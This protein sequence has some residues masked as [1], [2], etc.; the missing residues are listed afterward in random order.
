MAIWDFFKT[1]KKPKASSLSEDSSEDE[2]LK[3]I[4][5]KQKEMRKEK[6]ALWEQQLDNLRMRQEQLKM[7]KEIADIESQLSEFD[8][9]DDDGEDSNSSD[10]MSPEALLTGIVT[11]SLAA[12]KQTITTEAP[13]QTSL[14]TFSDEQIRQLKEQLPSIYKMQLHILSDDQVKAMIK[15]KF[16]QVDNDTLNRAVGILR[17]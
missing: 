15:M 3:R 7:E 6:L 14:L 10:P 11:S 5:K 9:E 1:R 12:P 2:I 16:P 17:E 8:F 13:G 4:Q